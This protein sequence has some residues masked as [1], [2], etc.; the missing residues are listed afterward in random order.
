MSTYYLLAIG[1][2]YLDLS[3]FILAEPFLD[4]YSLCVAYSY[5]LFVW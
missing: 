2:V 5:K 1:W 3:F 4:A